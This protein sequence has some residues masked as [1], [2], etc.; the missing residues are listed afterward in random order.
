MKRKLFITTL[1]IVF[2]LAAGCEKEDERIDNFLVDFATV[3]HSQQIVFFQ[4]DNQRILIPKELKNYSGNNGQRVILNYTPLRGDT[5]KVNDVAD[6][7][8]GE[9]QTL[10]IFQQIYDDPVK[11]QSLWVGGDYLNMVFETEYHS[12]SHLIGL[13]RDMVSPTVDLYFSHFRNNDPPGYPQTFYVS[14]LISSLRPAG[15][16]DP[17]SFRLF[18]NT[19][20]GMREFDLELK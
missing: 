11:I 6:I 7:F 8:T 4:L 17:V 10:K 14:F 18:V 13:F 3:L 15:S 16:S 1:I 5:I 2:S 9:I 19:Y 12:R 20:T